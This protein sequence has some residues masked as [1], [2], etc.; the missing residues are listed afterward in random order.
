MVL[1]HGIGNAHPKFLLA[2]FL[3]T[4]VTLL[5]GTSQ[6]KRRGAKQSKAAAAALVHG[7]SSSSLAPAA[8]QAGHLAIAY[9]GLVTPAGLFIPLFSL[10]VCVLIGKAFST[11]KSLQ[12]EACDAHGTLGRSRSS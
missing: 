5:C 1:I 11:S 7:S 2:V 8:R 6:K 9:A 10:I 12:L 3:A 4:N